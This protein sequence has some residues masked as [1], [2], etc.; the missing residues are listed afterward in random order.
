MTQPRDKVFISY[1]HKDKKWLDRLQ[2]TLK[3]LP[4]SIWADTQ[5]KAGAKWSEEITGALSSA[6]VAVLLVSQS[7]LS[8]EFIT[9]EELPALLEAAEKDGVTILWVALEA[10]LYDETEISKYQSLNNPARPLDKLKGATLSEELVNIA[11]QIKTAV[12]PI[13]Q[14]TAARKRREIS[15]LATRGNVLRERRDDLLKDEH[16]ADAS[17]QVPAQK[18]LLNK[19]TLSYL[20][21][22]AILLTG[23]IVGY[24][25]IP[26]TEIP[27]TTTAF[28]DD[29]EVFNEHRWSLPASGWR[30]ESDGRL[31]LQSASV[32]LY[33]K[34]QNYRDFV[35]NFHLKL[36]DAGGAAWAVRV[37]DERNYYLFYLSGPGGMFPGR[38]NVYI[39]KDGK[40]DPKN[41]FN[42]APAL[43]KVREAGQYDVEVTANA[44]LIESKIIS[45]DDGQ[46]IK[47]ISFK[48][49]NDTFPSGSIGFRTVGSESFS[50]DELNVAPPE[51]Q[52]PR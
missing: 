29:F 7:F 48:D 45:A 42:S 2:T 46:E 23:V 18:W 25:K 4:I 20:A 40:F 26:Q 22:L 28:G 50:I 30:V 49:P 3:P 19:K 36:T 16:V 12:G 11:K 35:M 8:S 27:L 52:Q 31:H 15:N 33:P 51:A 1:S 21:A 14:E 32:V 44:G 38:I 5:I 34:G 17:L 43:V 37:R 6:K 47:L 10:C 41:H 13:P 39:V 9:N 24:F